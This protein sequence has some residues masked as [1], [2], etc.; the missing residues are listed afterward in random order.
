M[1]A[2]IE[3]VDVLLPGRYGIVAAVSAFFDESHNDT[4]FCVAGYI[5]QKARLKRFDAG[6]QYMLREYALPF[7]RMSACAHGN[8]PFDRLSR[9]E[10]I[11]VATKAISLI[12]GHASCGIAIAIERKNFKIPKNKIV[13]SPYELCAWTSLVGIAAWLAEQRETGK[14]AYF[15]EAGD[16]AEGHAN[17]LMHKIFS[18]PKLHAMYHYSSHSFIE[19][20]SCSAVQA[21]DVLAWQ[22]LQECK[23]TLAGESKRRKDYEQLVGTSARGLR[24]YVVFHDDAVMLSR[25][26]MRPDAKASWLA[27]ISEQSS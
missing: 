21:A 26:Y 1:S 22:F 3:L 5:F 19:K 8:K 11:K 6:W 4:V 17:A 2:F 12:R 7:F 10:Q 23:R 18:I 27:L 9:D 20:E 13:V 16:A 15:F 24:H 25:G 14:V